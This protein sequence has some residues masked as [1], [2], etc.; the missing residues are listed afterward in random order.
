M[1]LLNSSVSYCEP[2]Q[3][4][5]YT[6]THFISKG[7]S[8]LEVL[9]GISSVLAVGLSDVEE[10]LSHSDTDPSP[11]PIASAILEGYRLSTQDNCSAAERI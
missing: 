8:N 5:L 6:D 4:S 1:E 11:W 2:D 10:D 9:L 3:K 7:V